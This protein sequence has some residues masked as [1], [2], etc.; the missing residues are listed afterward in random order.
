MF[1]NLIADGLSFGWTI[2]ALALT[3]LILLA[4]ASLVTTSNLHHKPTPVSFRT[5]INPFTELKFVLLALAAFFVFWGVFIPINYIIVYAE[6]LGMSTNLSNYQLVILNASRW[7]F[8]PDS[9]IPSKRTMLT[10]DTRVQRPRTHPMRR[11]SRQIRLPQYNNHQR[12]KRRN[13]YLRTLVHKHIRHNNR[14][15]NTLRLGLRVI[16]LAAPRV[17]CSDL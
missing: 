15:R 4:F 8:S 2:R 7:D 17:H 9:T 10:I 1:N 12:R 11:N 5:F 3:F 6:S 13:I 14:F 16:H